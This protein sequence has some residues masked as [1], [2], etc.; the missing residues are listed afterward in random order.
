[1]YTPFTEVRSHRTHQ[2]HE[3]EQAHFAHAAREAARA[4]RRE[5][6]ARLPWVRFATHPVT[7][8]AVVFGTLVAGAF[9]VGHSL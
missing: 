7:R 1:M 2:K 9:G 3:S 4:H 5:A 6:R 8:R